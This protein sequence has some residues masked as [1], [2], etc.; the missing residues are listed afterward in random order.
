MGN[1]Q[2]RQVEVELT[3]VNYTPGSA[4]NLEG[5]LEGIDAALGSG[6][7]AIA[8]HTAAQAIAIANTWEDLI[9]DT[10]VLLTGWTHAVSTALFTSPETA[11][12]RAI[13]Q[14]HAEQSG[15]GTAPFGVR[16][17]FNGVEIP[18]SARSFE[19]STNNVSNLMTVAFPFNAVTSQDFKVQVS[20]SGTMSTVLPATAAAP[21][22]NVSAALEIAR[23]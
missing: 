9:F 1:Q 8:Y 3:P 12:F 17:L 23:L 20:G 16:F 22:T 6:D 13:L 18:G 14:L 21:V 19:I 2:A 7:K 10:N 11:L 4:A 15:G 5:D